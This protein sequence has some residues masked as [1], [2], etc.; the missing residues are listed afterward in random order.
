MRSFISKNESETLSYAAGFANTLKNGDIVALYGTLGTGKTVFSKGVIR[1]L[2]KSNIDVPSPTFTIVQSYDCD[3]GVIYHFDFYR[4]K[5]PQE[6]FEIGIE[7][8]F[9][10][11]ICLIEWPEK[12]T[13]LLPKKHISVHFKIDGDN[14][15]IEIQD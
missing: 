5:N 7:D 11:G 15:I 10:D 13:S 14:H 12:I 4:L 3:K 8:A 1:A 6:A 9:S 2:S